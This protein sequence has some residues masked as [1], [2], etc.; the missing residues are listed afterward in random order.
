[1]AAIKEVIEPIQLNNVRN[2]YC[3][4]LAGTFI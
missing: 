3:T 1:M 4:T 2:Q